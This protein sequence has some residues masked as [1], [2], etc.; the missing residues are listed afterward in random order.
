MSGAINIGYNNRTCTDGG[1]CVEYNILYDIPAAQAVFQPNVWKSV[2]FAPLDT[3]G[4]LR[5]VGENYQ[6]MLGSAKDANPRARLT[7]HLLMAYSVWWQFYHFWPFPSSFRYYDTPRN[8]S[9]VLMD[10]QVPLMLILAKTPESPSLDDVLSMEMKNLTVTHDG[11]TVEDQASG[12]AVNVAM[13]W[14]AEPYGLAS[15]EQE[16]VESLMLPRPPN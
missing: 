15:V 16:L 5:V 13:K 9:S 14:K 7:R 10:A 12:V 4:A 6:A 1:D 8:S 3:A 11:H 2:T